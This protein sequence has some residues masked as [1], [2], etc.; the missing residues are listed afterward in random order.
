MCSLLCT[1]R[2]NKPGLSW[3]I[4]LFI[5]F[6]ERAK[7]FPS[8]C[9]SLAIPQNDQKIKSIFSIIYHHLHICLFAHLPINFS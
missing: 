4:G 8:L 3:S 6:I 7:R 9:R 2:E 1:K 5:L